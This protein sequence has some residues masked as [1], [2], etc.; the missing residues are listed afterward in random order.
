MTRRIN[1]VYNDMFWQMERPSPETK[2][3][4][5]STRLAMTVGF[6]RESD[7]AVDRVRRMLG[8]R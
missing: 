4:R 1:Q 8:V 7:P 5:A 2:V 6:E 3:R